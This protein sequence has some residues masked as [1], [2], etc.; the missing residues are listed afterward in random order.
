MV[1][2]GLGSAT[3]LPRAP[4][5]N[6]NSAIESAKGLILVGRTRRSYREST[7]T[8]STRRASGTVAMSICTFAAQPSAVTMGFSP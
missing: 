5:P 6:L 3:L 7:E 2:V 4:R 8:F 1:N